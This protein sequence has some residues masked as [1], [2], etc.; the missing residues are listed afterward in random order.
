[1]STPLTISQAAGKM[2]VHVKTLQRWDR[3]GKLVGR[4][5]TTGRRYYTQ[6]QVDEYLRT[7]KAPLPERRTLAYC[8]VSSAAQKP[9]LLNQIRRI[10]ETPRA[11]TCAHLTTSRRLDG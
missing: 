9:D 3:E 4:R 7:P 8:R 6:E 11:R 5:T 1:M 2:G 10:R